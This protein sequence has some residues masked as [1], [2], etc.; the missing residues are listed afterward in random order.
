MEG[1]QPRRLPALRFAFPGE[2]AAVGQG[3]LDNL[4]DLRAGRS[5]RDLVTVHHDR[6]AS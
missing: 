6:E 1:T 4:S 2:V 5:P 3:F